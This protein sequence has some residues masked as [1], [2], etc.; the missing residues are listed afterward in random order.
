MKTIT[1]II[2]VREGSRRL[3]NK[4]IAPFAGT[5]LLINKI[6]QLKQV[7]E[8]NKIVVSSDSETMLAMA[9]ANGV[10]IHKRAIEFCDEKTKTF[11]EVVKHIAESVSGEII[12]WATCTSPLV[13]PKDY[14]Q[15][16]TEYRKALDN[17]FDSL[18]S[19]ESFKRYIWNESSPLNYKLGL[20]HVP[21]QQLPTLYFVTDGI[22]IAPREK[23]IEWSYFHGRNP[24]KFVV[25]KRT[26]CDIDDGLDLACARA[27]LD[28]DESVSQIDPYII[29]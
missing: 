13:F 6:N 23:M 8:I 17:G 11:G 21:S 4:N 16:I 10:D 12:L 18:M 14:S 20:K 7:S 15:A 2:P 3:K 9:K 1:A 24:Y 25:N 5:N 29:K 26:G 19:V 22:L 28:M 27:W